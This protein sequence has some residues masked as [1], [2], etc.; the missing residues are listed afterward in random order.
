M[1]QPVMPEGQ[2]LGVMED[3]KAINPEVWPQGLPSRVP[4]LG[5]LALVQVPG[6]KPHNPPLKEATKRV[7]LTMPTGQEAGMVPVRE[8]DPRL[9]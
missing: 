9:S 3:I 1:D 7:R 6:N 4:L 5:T 2:E 8:L